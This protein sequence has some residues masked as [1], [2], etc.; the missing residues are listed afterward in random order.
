MRR[1]L[2]IALLSVGLF[3]SLRGASCAQDAET[4]PDCVAIA[5]QIQAQT[6]VRFVRARKSAGGTLVSDP[7]STTELGSNSMTLLCPHWALDLEPQSYP[8]V[9]TIWAGGSE[10]PSKVFYDLA[11]HAGTILHGRET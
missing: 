8:Y 5:A 11:S 7:S 1:P 9:V 6:H 3:L 10:D 2:A 4:P